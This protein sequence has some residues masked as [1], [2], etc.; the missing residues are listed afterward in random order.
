MLNLGD[1]PYVDELIVEMGQGVAVAMQAAPSADASKTSLQQ[2]AKIKRS[3]Y[4]NLLANVA[5]PTQEPSPLVL[6]EP[7]GAVPETAVLSPPSGPPSSIEK[8]PRLEFA[9]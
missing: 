2:P 7:G 8:P 1:A 5:L 4:E 9:A 6:G 3:V